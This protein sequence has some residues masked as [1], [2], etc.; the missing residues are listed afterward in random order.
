MGDE[1]KDKVEATLPM[2]IE[3]PPLA[4]PGLPDVVGLIV[5]LGVK[6]RMAEVLGEKLKL[7]IEGALHL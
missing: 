7:P 1:G 2:K 3:M 4:D 6:R 5:L